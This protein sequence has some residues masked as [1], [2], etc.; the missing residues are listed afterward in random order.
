ME[1]ATHD[2][3]TP[4]PR[5][6]DAPA[7][8]QLAGTH[9]WLVLILLCTAQFIVVLDFSVVNV[10]LPSIQHDL[11][12]ST[13]NLQWIISAYS[14]TFGGLLLLGGRIGDLFGRRRF[15]MV[16]LLVFAV[17][18]LLGGLAQSQAWLIG[19]R[20]LQGV[21]AALVAPISF[22]LITTTFAEGPAR[23]RALGVTGAMA[24][25][26]FAAG[27]ILGGVL[28]AGPGW[29]WVFFINV[30]VALA[31]VICSPILLPESAKQTGTQRIDVLGA[32][33][34]TV[35]LTTF[36]Y[37][38]TRGNEVGWASAQ[39]LGLLAFAVVCLAA[40]VLI[41]ARVQAPLVR[42]GIF[43]QRTL[44]GANLVGLF[45][46][47][48][49]GATIFTLTLYLQQV[50]NYSPLTTGLAFLPLAAV[51]GLTSNLV[52]PVLPR[53]GVRRLLVG[54]LF[55][56]AIGMLLLLLIRPANQYLT[57][58]LPGLL[59]LSLGMGPVFTLMAI[60]ATNGVRDAE[61]GLASG[62]LNT[63]QSIGS[64]LV[65]AVVVAVSAARTASLQAQGSDMPTALVG[66]AHAGLIVGAGFVLVA[67]AIALI[68]IRPQTPTVQRD[69]RNH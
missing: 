9:S 16:G 55:V 3:S 28:T 41:E 20:A 64:G 60:A 53:F 63:T 24:S 15:F 26:G 59:V 43:R 65:L 34:V 50:L 37:V 18:S 8:R 40:F 39:T 67:F 29:P 47:G 42:L 17:A 19:A 22:S 48:A 49:F 27:A 51:V 10:A 11:G 36:V 25:I 2:A 54:G 21:G 57:T 13:Q 45:A 56:V 33:T 52:A 69:E 35:S 46:P 62:L 44:T 12:F 66:G 5:P 38:L 23:N 6:A 61:Q 31:A 4:H 14:L 7:A 68:V 1:N 32:I 30:P 58:L